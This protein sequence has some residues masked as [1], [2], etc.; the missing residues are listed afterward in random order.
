MNSPGQY[1]RLCIE[2]SMGNMDTDV[3][4]KSN[5]HLFI[6][7]FF[8]FQLGHCKVDETEKGWFIAYIDRD[9][10]TIERQKV[11][12]VEPKILLLS[13]YKRVKFINKL[14]CCISGRV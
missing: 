1:Q 10:D 6:I 8:F 5:F 14:W 7:A 11:H 4:V 12:I 3:R 13:L 9:P 2:E